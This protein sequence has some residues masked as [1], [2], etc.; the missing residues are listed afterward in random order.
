MNYDEWGEV[1]DNVE[2][3]VEMILGSVRPFAILF[4]L[5]GLPLAWS[6]LITPADD[7]RMAMEH[8]GAFFVLCILGVLAVAEWWFAGSEWLADLDESLND[9]TYGMLTVSRGIAWLGVMSYHTFVFEDLVSVA[10]AGI[11]VAIA[12]SGPLNLLGFVSMVAGL[13]G[14]VAT[15]FIRRPILIMAR[16]LGFGGGLVWLEG[17]GVLGLF[18]ILVL[19]PLVALVLCIALGLTLL[20]VLWAMRAWERAHDA[21]LRRPCPHC[22]T[23]VRM[24]A[25]LCF[26]CQGEL[27][28]VHP[29]APPRR[30][31]PTDVVPAS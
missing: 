22:D 2:L 23:P 19:A 27:D 5:F 13:V 31:P 11:G 25:C 28:I 21:K 10:P 20:A 30:K 4:V 26:N 1:V 9:E 7:V 8:K 12:A 17:L 29:L 24:E 14:H 18:A 3:F 16:E 15:A 6:Y